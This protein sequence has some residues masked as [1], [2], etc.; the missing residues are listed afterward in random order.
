MARY[1]M[2]LLQGWQESNKIERVEEDSE[3]VAR[4]V[5]I[6]S[7]EDT[8]LHPRVIHHALFSFGGPGSRKDAGYYRRCA[9]RVGK[10]IPVSP[11]KVEPLMQDWWWAVLNCGRL[12]S[13]GYGRTPF[14]PYHCWFETIHPF[15]D[16]NG[17]V[18]RLLMWNLQMVRGDK[19]LTVPTY[20]DR[21][22][23]YQLLEDWR[24]EKR[25]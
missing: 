8:L 21:F 10:Y 19:Q 22:D 23:Y 20:E 12:D 4:M 7:Q 18:G 11:D 17:R 9:V 5:Q 3:R 25:T 24:K 6:A 16:G 1:D 2:Q 13:E 15:E 14:T